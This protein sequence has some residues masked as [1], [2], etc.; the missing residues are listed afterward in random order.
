MMPDDPTVSP[1]RTIFTPGTTRTSFRIAIL[2]AA[3]MHGPVRVTV[4]ASVLIDTS[5][6]WPTPDIMTRSR[7]DSA[8]FWFDMGAAAGA[9]LVVAV[10][11]GLVSPASATP[12]THTPSAAA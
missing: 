9:V 1:S 7:T 8:N 12:P 11:A 5:D 4:P 3:S 6:P 2:W 10:L